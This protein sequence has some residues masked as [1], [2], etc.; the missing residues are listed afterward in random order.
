MF[1]ILFFSVPNAYPQN[2]VGVASSPR[3]ALFTWEPPSPDKQNGI[4]VEYLINITAANTGETFQQSTAENSL[5]IDNLKPY[6]TYLCIVA[7]STSAGIGPFST[8][9]S[10]QT[11]EDGKCN[12][13]TT[14]ITCEQAT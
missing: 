2:F 3:S 12:I 5:R 8:V 6:T 9:L 14:E 11:P 10:I 7:A 13:N 4:I 1:L